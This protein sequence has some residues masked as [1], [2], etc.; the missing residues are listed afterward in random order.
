MRR[1]AAGASMEAKGS[2]EG[3]AS[4]RRYTDQAAPAVG[5]GDDGRGCGR[6]RHAP[7]V[8]LMAIGRRAAEVRGRERS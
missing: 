7:V 3:A 2:C 6:A 8:A 4:G 1:R 5:R